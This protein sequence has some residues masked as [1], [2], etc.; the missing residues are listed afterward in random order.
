MESLD[1]NMES[2]N[3]INKKNK[4][5]CQKVLFDMIREYADDWKS[6]EEISREVQSTSIIP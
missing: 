2:S 6:V 1:S 4:K 3:R 5:V